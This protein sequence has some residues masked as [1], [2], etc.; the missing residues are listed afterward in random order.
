MYRY[1]YIV[2]KYKIYLYQLLKQ[3]EEQASDELFWPLSKRAQINII[4]TNNVCTCILCLCQKVQNKCQMQL[5]STETSIPNI[6]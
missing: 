5:K 3:V 1:M 6:V 2:G 4:V